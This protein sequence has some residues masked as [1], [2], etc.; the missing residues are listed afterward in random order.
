[1]NF[2]TLLPFLAAFP[3]MVPAA[4]LLPSNLFNISVATGEHGKSVIQCWQLTTPPSLATIGSGSFQSQT[5][6]KAQAVSINFFPPGLSFGSHP[7]PVVQ[8][9]IVLSGS[10]KIYLQNQTD[11]ADTVFV[12]GG[13]SGVLLA[14]D[15]AD[16]SPIGHVTE[17]V[18]ETTML[19]MS[20][21]NGTVPEHTVLHNGGC[22]GEDLV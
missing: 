17:T 16:I 2:T 19:F 8:W 21:A 13:K 6:G 15:T 22:A 9:V 4:A 14:A 18:E 20:T 7:A 12:S 11:Q 5:L 1:M 3:S 10:I